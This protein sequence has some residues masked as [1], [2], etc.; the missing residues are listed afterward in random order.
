MRERGSFCRLRNLNGSWDP[1]LEAKADEELAP[2]GAN[3]TPAAARTE[4]GRRLS[5]V[6]R[7]TRRSCQAFRQSVD[8]IFFLNHKTATP[9]ARPPTKQSCICNNLSKTAN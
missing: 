2:I 1:I 4:I 7:T 8:Y 5:A 9:R 3:G 6:V